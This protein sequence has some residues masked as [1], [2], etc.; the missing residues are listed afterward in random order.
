MEAKNDDNLGAANEP[1]KINEETT[2][3]WIAYLAL[4]GRP[5]INYKWNTVK[6]HE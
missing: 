2:R 1:Q 4:H 5:T 6:T 3:I